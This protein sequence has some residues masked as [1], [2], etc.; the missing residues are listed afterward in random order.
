[1]HGEVSGVMTLNS[2]VP[3]VGSHTTPNNHDLP[4][5]F[6]QKKDARPFAQHAMQKLSTKTATEQTVFCRARRFPLFCVLV[7]ILSWLG[8]L[9]CA[10]RVVLCFVLGVLLLS[11]YAHEPNGVLFSAYKRTRDG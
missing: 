5:L 3:F 8:Y 9:V 11:F 10:L 1:M 2:M 6:P 7:C 4:S